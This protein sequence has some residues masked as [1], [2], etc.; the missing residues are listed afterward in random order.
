M[1]AGLLVA[2]GPS[3]GPRLYVHLLAWSQLC[4]LTPR[5]EY[6]DLGHEPLLVWLPAASGC[7][8]DLSLGGPFWDFTGS[9]GDYKCL[10]VGHWNSRQFPGGKKHPCLELGSL[11]SPVRGVQGQ[12]VIQRWNYSQPQTPLSGPLSFPGFPP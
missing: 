12:A 4:P 5:L 6:D 10:S 2:P 3:Q 11:L 9:L 7:D 1:R 8:M